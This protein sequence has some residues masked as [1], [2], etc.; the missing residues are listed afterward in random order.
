MN[1]LKRI[2]NG[3]VKPKNKTIVYNKSDMVSILLD[4]IDSIVVNKE[5]NSIIINTKKNIV[6]NNDG[7][8]IFYNSGMQVHIGKQI[9]LN[10]DVN[11]A[12]N[13]NEFDLLEQELQYSIDKQFS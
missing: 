3:V 12:S 1:I 4:T 5:Q 9:H 2:Y 13:F 10:P 11:I 7:H 6:L 8:T